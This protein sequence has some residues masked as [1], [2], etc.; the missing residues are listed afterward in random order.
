[1]AT[2][3]KDALGA[4]TSLAGESVRKAAGLAEGAVGAL[5][6]R[7]GDVAAD[8]VKNAIDILGAA[9]NKGQSMLG[10]RDK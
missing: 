9:A 3:P 4:A 1:M 6:T 8:V 2:N 10:K 7:A 5:K